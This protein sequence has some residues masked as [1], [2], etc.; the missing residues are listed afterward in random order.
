MKHAAEEFKI[1]DRLAKMSK[2]AMIKK[3]ATDFKTV[4]PPKLYTSKND[5]AFLLAQAMGLLNQK[6][7]TDA[8]IDLRLRRRFNAMD[9]L[10]DMAI[11]GVVRSL[12]IVGAPGLGKTYNVEKKLREYDPQKRKHNVIRGYATA[13]NLYKQLWDHRAEGRILVLDDCDAVRDDEVGLNLLKVATDSSD[14]RNISYYAENNLT[15]D[16]D[17][18]R[19]PKSFEFNGTVIFITNEDLEH[20]AQGTGGNSEHMAALINR[21][22]YVNLTLRDR[23]D[24]L[25]RIR[26][27]V[28]EGVMLG[29]MPDRDVKDVMD[30]VEKHHVTLRDLS[31]RTV[32]K[33]A[34]FKK[35]KPDTWQIHCEN[36]MFPN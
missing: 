4:L 19:I 26:Q 24:A 32:I 9:E 11:Q 12:I 35:A 34:D 21:A 2:E 22:H 36:T 6:K 28:A 31:L 16:S 27:V 13:V 33:I 29:G 8:E 23:R 10:T 17:G 3:L 14:V 7:E 5:A 1:P 20:Q 18:S 30:Y 25:V 15:S